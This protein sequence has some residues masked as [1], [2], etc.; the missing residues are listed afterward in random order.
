MYATWTLATLAVA[1]YGLA[2]APGSSWSRPSS[3]THSRR[4][5]RSSGRRSNSATSRRRCSAAFRASTGRSRSACFHCRSHSRPRC[6]APR[7]ANDPG[8]QRDDRRSGDAGRP[9][10][11]RDARHRGLREHG[12]NDGRQTKRPRCRAAAATGISRCGRPG[13]T[14]ARSAKKDRRADHPRAKR[15]VNC[16]EAPD[17]RALHVEMSGLWALRSVP[18]PKQGLIDHNPR[19]SASWPGERSEAADRTAKP[20]T[21]AL[22]TEQGPS[23]GPGS[24]GSN[25]CPAAS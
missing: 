1:G 17:G 25:P 20:R 9:L 8:R 6:G 18:V 19:Q 4:Q 2:T 22:A 11:P 21:R 15:G 13:L 24:W 7:R 10:P 16:E 23:S 12:R 5:G 3:S 14:I